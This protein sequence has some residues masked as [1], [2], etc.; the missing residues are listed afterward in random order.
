LTPVTKKALC[1]GI[2]DYP[3][4]EMD[5][6]GCVN[7]ALAW[8]GLLRKRFDFP[9]ANVRVLRDEAATHDHVTTALK[10][11]LTNAKSGDVLVFTN[12]SHGTYVADRASEEADSYDEAMCPYDCRK[13]LLTDDELR[14]LFTDIPRGVR[15]T[16][17]SDSCHSGS[18][19]R[20][21]QG[22][23]TPDDRRVRYLSPKDLRRPEIPD[24][25]HRASP[26]R[27]EVHPE[28][29]MRELLLSGC[30]SNQYSYDARFGNTYHGAMTWY[31][32]KVI[33]QAGYRLSYSTLAK[34]LREALAESNY[35]QEPQLEGR[36]TFKRRQI[37]T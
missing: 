7:D 5:L 22:A 36:S 31:A 21:A 24:V 28:S 33:E 19:T 2:N 4:P 15:L 27:P 29:E 18:V 25:R 12:S 13:N 3:I 16:V 26:K 35:D 20:V 8:A 14:T 6:K 11:L 37:F 23:A 1:V 9:S 32:L 34:R 17:I 10:A 30:R